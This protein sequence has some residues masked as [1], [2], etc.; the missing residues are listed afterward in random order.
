M[1]SVT[2]DF[3]VLD[4]SVLCGFLKSSQ[5]LGILFLSLVLSFLFLP[6]QLC[7]LFS[8]VFDKGDLSRLLSRA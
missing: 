8:L 6:L 4:K 5:S 1:F 7:I 2:G 3:L